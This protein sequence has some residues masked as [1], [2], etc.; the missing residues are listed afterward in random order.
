MKK[1]TVPRFHPNLAPAPRRSPLLLALLGAFTLGI[2]RPPVAAAVG[3]AVLENS[4][5][6]LVVRDGRIV[7]LLDKTR[8]LEHVAASPGAAP[9]PG[10]FQIQW[11]K[12]IQ[13]TGTLDATAMKSRVSRRTER[14]LELE[15]DHPEAAVRATLALA[16]NPGEIE[17]SLSVTPRNPL[18]ALARVDF[19]L[20]ATPN[21]DAGKEKQCLLPYREGRLTPLHLPLSDE[22][23]FNFFTYPKHLF[24]Q[25]IACLGEK[26]G[27]L[28]WTDDQL[29]HV[30]EFG[31]DHDPKSSVFRIRH[32]F[33]YEPGKPRELSYRSRITLTGSAWQDAADVYRDWTS[34]QPWAT[35]KLTE[36]TDIPGILRSPPVCVSGQIEQEDLDALPA[37]LKA[38][39]KHYGAPV[40]YRPLGWE[41]HGN[42]MGIDYFPPSIGTARFAATAQR[43]RDEGIMVAGFISGFAWKT[44]LGKG[45]GS[46]SNRDQ[47][48]RLLEQHF[49]ENNGP[50][51]C[52]LDRNGKVRQPSRICRGTD[53]GR[54]FLPNTARQLFDLGVGVIHD[55][56][57]FG[58]FQF[59]SEGCFNPAHGHPI[60]GGT[61]EIDV[62]RQAFQAI[63]EEARRRGK[64]DYFLSKEGYTELLMQDLHA[65]QARFFKAATEPHHAPLAQYIFHEYV[66]SIFGWGCDNQP[67]SPQTA[68][69]LV[70]GQ[71]PCFPSWGKAISLPR[72]NRMVSDYY[73]AMRSHAKDFLLYGR[74]RRPLAP[75][76]PASAPLIQSAW[77]DAR[78]NVGVFAINT[79][80]QETVL[81]VPAP[82]DGQWEAT[83]YVGASAQKQQVVTA[84]QSLEWRLPAGRLASIILA[85]ANDGTP[86]GRTKKEQIK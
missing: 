57:D 1:S 26:G 54:N 69:L 5:A 85:P 86:D 39:G 2:L 58:T 15:F 84:G 24:A 32:F 37:K 46:A 6:R 12:G 16:D 56:V 77:D 74:M 18:L 79:Q 4:A 83:F 29:G 42:W 75:A 27:F 59:E 51:L 7:S 60:P 71:I 73:D 33:A 21:V 62:T 82:G 13:P 19:P 78:G 20:L 68:M 53:F 50:G 36:R 10:L 47:T 28:L 8:A 80:R 66:F 52:E 11:V 49:R 9:S 63:S 3:D 22:T 23:T 17:C 44:R 14:E 25:M 40:I 72:P 67:L 81:R 30:K 43:L 70:Y 65:S 76:R 61:W 34:R 35:V 31:R 64:R 48:T 45:E 41:K 38:W 55:D